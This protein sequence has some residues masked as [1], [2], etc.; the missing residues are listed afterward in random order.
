MTESA[1]AVANNTVIEFHYRLFDADNQKL[2]DTNTG[3]PQATLIGHHRLLQGVEAAM[4]GKYGGESLII[5]LPP[6]RAYGVRD[7]T[8]VERIPKKYFA[9][10]KL[11]RPGIRTGLRRKQGGVQPVTVVKVGAKVVDVDLNH[12]YAGKTVT[13]E[14]DLL[15]VRAATHDEIKQ[16]QV[17]GPTTNSR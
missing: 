14:L 12:P 9:N 16:K 8:R 6:E 13:F 1:I 5:T 7:E 17:R 11:L 4:L 2:E 10:P 15:S 3:A